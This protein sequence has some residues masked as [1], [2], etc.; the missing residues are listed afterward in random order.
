VD[1]DKA[2]AT[3]AAFITAGTITVITWAVLSNG[4]SFP[5]MAYIIEHLALSLL[6]RSAY[7]SFDGS[8]WIV[9]ALTFADMIGDDVTEEA[10]AEAEVA[11]AA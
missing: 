4:Q 9:S 11:K 6:F 5:P 7:K 3:Y 1:N 10:S 8:N 2:F